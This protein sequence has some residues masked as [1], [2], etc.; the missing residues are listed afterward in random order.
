M[1]GVL[2]V[3]NKQNEI[4]Y[5]T[6]VSGKLAE[7]NRHKQFIPPV[8]DMLVKD[9][10]YLQ[11]K[12]VL[13]DMSV[14]IDSLENSTDY[15]ELIALYKSKGE[16]ADLDIREKKEDLKTTK[17]ERDLR[18]D[19]AKIELSAEVYTDFENT[20]SKESLKAK[21][22][23]T[24]AKTINCDQM[25]FNDR[26]EFLVQMDELTGG[27]RTFPMIFHNNEFVGGYHESIKRVMND[28]SF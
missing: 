19:K 7:T 2:V 15:L 22:F 3:Q 28:I 17:N 12:G 8:Y 21:H 4:G 13:N 20:L 5:I 9:S 26:D 18:R 24:E 23:F 14:E 11:E 16:K 25:L 10:Y 27:H 1:F 6:A